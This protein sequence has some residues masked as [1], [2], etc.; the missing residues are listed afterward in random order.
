MPN[1]P[2]VLPPER[3]VE[4]VYK[5]IKE[6]IEEHRATAGDWINDLMQKT[7]PI[8]RATMTDRILV[9]GGDP[10][11]RNELVSVFS[12]AGFTVD[13]VSDY[14]EALSKLDESKPDIVI[15]DEALPSKDSMEACSELYFSFGIPVVLL[16]ED[17]SDEVWERVMEVGADLYQLKPFGYLP[18]VARVKAIL[19]RYKLCTS[20]SG[21]GR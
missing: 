13:N 19:R 17:A 2:R 20:R 10:S 1:L 18:L 16:G 11:L 15:M 4:L 3:P 21:D 7:V 14:P 8:R 9:I 6:A 5:G 12:E